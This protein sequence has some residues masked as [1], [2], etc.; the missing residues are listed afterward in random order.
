MKLF[1]SD[2][3]NTLF[4]RAADPSIA[5]DVRHMIHAF[6]SQGHL[7][8]LCTGRPGRGFDPFINGAFRPDFIIAS[9]GACILGPEGQV[10]IQHAL[11]YPVLAEIETLGRSF[12]YY[13][14]VHADGEFLLLETPDTVPWPFVGRIPSVA[15]VRDRQVHGISFLAGTEEKAAAFLSL[16]SSRFPGEISAFRNR[17]AVDIVP[18]GCSKGEGLLTAC[19]YFGADES[20]GIGDS[21]NDLPLL[22][23]AGTAFTFPDAP[24][25]LRSAA[26]RIVPD[27]AAAL[28]IALGAA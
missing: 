9:S 28:R 16:L 12:G 23:S 2:F 17:I 25:E 10:L 15:S 6:Q 27:A 7:F 3:D 5:E 8:G 26:D 13:G 19:R 11:P 20:Y 21:M 4:F 14:A 1:A 22:L 18:A 24:E